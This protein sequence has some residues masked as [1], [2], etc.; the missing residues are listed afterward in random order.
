MLASYKSSSFNRS[1]PFC[2][3]SGCIAE[4]SDCALF[5]DLQMSKMLKRVINDLNLENQTL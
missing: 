2:E 1:V 5:F 3:S 4:V